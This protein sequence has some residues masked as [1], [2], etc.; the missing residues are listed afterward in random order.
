MKRQE[1]MGVIGSASSWAL[2]ASAQN[3]PSVWGLSELTRAHFLDV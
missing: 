3:H 1:F 2:A